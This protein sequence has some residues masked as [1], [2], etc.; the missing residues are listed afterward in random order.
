MSSCVKW[1]GCKLTCLS[2]TIRAGMKRRGQGQISCSWFY[3]AKY[4]GR[5]GIQINNRLQ[6]S[7][8]FVNWRQ[9][10]QGAANSGCLTNQ[11]QCT[12]LLGWSLIDSGHYLGWSHLHTWNQYAVQM[13]ICSEP[14]SKTTHLHAT[15]ILRRSI[16]AP[17]LLLTKLRIHPAQKSINHSAN[18]SVSWMTFTVLYKADR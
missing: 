18:I 8:I 14:L 5:G 6:N 17:S 7:L 1:T 2:K 11:Y 12:L 16:T 13:F 10:M 15:L 9:I 3:F 4:F